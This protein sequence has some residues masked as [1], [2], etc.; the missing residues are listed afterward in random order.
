MTITLLRRRAARSFR[1]HRPPR[2]S[3]DGIL[4]VEHEFEGGPFAGRRMTGLASTVDMQVVRPERGGRA[5]LV[6]RVLRGACLGTY[7]FV[8]TYDC[9]RT[10]ERVHVYRWCV[11]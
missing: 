6:A 8:R 2:I 10:L 5:R 9:T 4:V 11:R 3:N 1:V 7:R